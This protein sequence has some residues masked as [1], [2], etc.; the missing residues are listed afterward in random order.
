MSIIL[1][2]LSQLF[3]DIRKSVQKLIYNKFCFQCQKW[4][5]KKDFITNEKNICFCSQNCLD[6]NKK[7]FEMM[8]D[9][10]KQLVDRILPESVLD[11]VGVYTDVTNIDKGE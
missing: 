11:S 4:L 6:N 7:I 3:Y 1:E 5:Y 2:D 8:K 9:L 10:V